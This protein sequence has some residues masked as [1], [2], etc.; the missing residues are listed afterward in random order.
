MDQ[1]AVDTAFT[2]LTKN[3]VSVRRRSRMRELLSKVAW[4]TVC[5]VMYDTALLAVEHRW[6]VT[7]TGFLSS[8]VVAVPPNVGNNDSASDC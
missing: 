3:L 4:R 7:D 6:L 5:G 1:A 8:V 2:V